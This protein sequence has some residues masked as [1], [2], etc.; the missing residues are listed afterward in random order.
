MQKGKNKEIS[1]PGA[2]LTLAIT[3]ELETVGKGLNHDP[4]L[5]KSTDKT[6]HTNTEPAYPNS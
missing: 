1:L 4:P 6:A 5:A 3:S 2:A